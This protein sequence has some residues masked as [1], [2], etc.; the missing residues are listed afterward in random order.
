M[1][2]R[3]HPAASIFPLV[4]GDEFQA[5]VADL[6]GHGQR[7]PITLQQD[8]S[9]LDGRNRY[10]ACVRLG[11]EPRFR[12]WNG[13]GSPLE[14]VLSLNLHRRQFARRARRG[15]QGWGAEAKAS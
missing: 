13:K 1:A 4:Q 15:W 11:I 3:F 8:G 2:V 14:F 10:R 6:K 12:T 9:I 5:L 7:E